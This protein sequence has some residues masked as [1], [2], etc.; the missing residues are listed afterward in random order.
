MA[1]TQNRAHHYRKRH[2]AQ[3]LHFP[4]IFGPMHTKYCKG[5]LFHIWNHLD[6]DG[7]EIFVYLNIKSTSHLDGLSE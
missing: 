7:D 4:P 6:L 2:D 3:A 5:Y 1:Y